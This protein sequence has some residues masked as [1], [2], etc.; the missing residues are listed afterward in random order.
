[1]C[2]FNRIPEIPRLG[3]APDLSFSSLLSTS[4][5]NSTSS[6]PL[7]D[8]NNNNNSNNNIQSMQ[9]SDSNSDL[10]E[11]ESEARVSA[12][13][14]PSQISLS[15]SSRLPN[16]PLPPLPQPSSSSL[17]SS[18]SIA[19]VAATALL[20][21]DLPPPIRSISNPII[22]TNTIDDIT[23][24]NT[25]NFSS[26]SSIDAPTPRTDG[27]AIS[28]HSILINVQGIFSPAE[29]FETFLNQAIINHRW[30]PV[31][32]H[33]AMT[34]WTKEADDILLDCIN[35]DIESEKKISQNPFQWSIS[36]K[37]ISHLTLTLSNL[38]N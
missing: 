38:F 24:K 25:L 33:Y 20:N 17:S 28:S 3:S 11:E 32:L 26:L 27:I 2:G 35:Q 15:L 18:S 8:N 21:I 1:M 12:N 5:R 9:I 10:E 7:H 36:A 37:N 22:P 23:P 16:P 14:T 6:Y 34:K 29:N 31:H 19:A 13:T 4:A 30:T